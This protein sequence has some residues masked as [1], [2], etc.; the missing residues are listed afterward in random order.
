[1]NKQPS[2]LSELAYAA[3]LVYSPR[4]NSDVSRQSRGIV[5]DIKQDKNGLIAFAAKRLLEVRSGSVLATILGPDVSLVPAPRSAPFPESGQTLWPARRICDELVR[6][7]LG[8]DTGACVERVTMVPKSAFAAKGH[9][10]SVTEH[11]ESMRA[12]ALLSKPQRTVVVDDVVT[13]G[14]T[15]LATASWVQALYPDLPVSGFALIRT[16]GYDEIT[17]ML[18]PCVGKI[19]WDGNDVYRDP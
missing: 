15:L 7:G 6:V 9:R 17:T 18:D 10:P 2:L 3:F 4:G 11:L 8:R 13:K 12:N 19:R 16:R 1:M 14:A 5:H